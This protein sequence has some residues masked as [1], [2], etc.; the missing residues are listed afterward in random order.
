MSLYPINPYGN[1]FYCQY[2]SYA[3]TKKDNIVLF[4]CL[5]M[6]KSYINVVTVFMERKLFEQF[7]DLPLNFDWASQK[8][9]FKQQSKEIMKPKTVIR[10]RS[11]LS[12]LYLIPHF[13]FHHPITPHL[14][15]ALP[16]SLVSMRQMR[17]V[18]AA[19][20]PIWWFAFV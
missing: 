10:R 9:Q 2:D 12:I 1:L 14:R 5:W 17:L 19:F 18:A 11:T 20:S 13:T 6:S 16:C 4:K 15:L 8:I 3:V 7:T